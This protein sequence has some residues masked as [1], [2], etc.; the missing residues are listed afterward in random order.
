MRK[1]G[2]VRVETLAEQLFFTTARL[3]C[4][5]G[6]T[7]SAGTGFV[8]GVEAEKK[9][10]GST[11]TAQFLVTNRHV[12]ESAMDELVVQMI[13][14]KPG[15]NAPDF[16]KP[17][18]I[19]VNAKPGWS[20]HP[21][22]EVDIAVVPFLAVLEGLEAAGTPTFYRSVPSVW[23]LNPQAAQAEFDAIEEVVF[24]GYPNNLYDQ[25]NLT[26]IMRRGATATSMALDYGGKPRFLIDA[27]VFPGSSGSPVFIM[28]SGTFRTRE[29]TVKVG[30]RLKL[31][32]ILAA[33][34]VRDVQANLVPAA[35]GVAFKDP[36]NLGIVY[37]ADAI[38]SI[39][40]AILDASGYRRA[41][42]Q[43]PGQPSGPTD[44]DKD[45]ADAA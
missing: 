11:G 24:V 15:E 30:Q 5:A 34:H 10:G 29:G 31:L 3:E 1:L 7:T 45:I 35:V 6:T 22:P 16:G 9:D 41:A 14:R 27:A 20:F 13:A 23:A 17:A 33:V 21:D 8:Y 44:T 37:R 4:R 12:A 32:G 18:A 38:D 28:D 40:D 36:L 19:R 2:R 43:D 39:I 26:P 42:P 25:T